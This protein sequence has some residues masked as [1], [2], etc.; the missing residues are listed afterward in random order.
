MKSNLT[1]S[2]S[3]LLFA[4]FWCSPI[5]LWAQPMEVANGGPFTPENLITNIF[6]G[7]GVE[8]LDVTFEGNAQS[9]GFFSN[10][11]D[12]IGI[13]RGLVMTTGRATSQ[14]GVGVDQN[15]NVQ[16]SSAMGTTFTDPDL[17]DITGGV[18]INDA[19][20]YTI[21]FVPIADTLRFNY[22]FGSEEYPEYA[23]SDF[24]DV[25]GF[26]ISGPGINGPYSNNAE[27][28]AL[29]P[30]SNLPVTINNVNPG[31]VGANGT[32][33]NCQPPSGSLDFS[34]FYVP[35]TGTANQPVFDG[36]TT[37][38]EAQAVVQPCSTYTIKLIV[39]D[40]SDSGWDSGVFLQAKSFG[41]GSLDVEAAT[42]SLDGSVAEGCAE[43]MLT[44]KLPNPPEADY[45]IDYQVLGTAENGVDYAFIP[46]DLFIPAGDTMVSVPIIAF[47]D[48]IEEG[49]ETILIDI[50]RDPCN[51]DTITIL[52]RENP[53]VPADLGPDTTICQGQSVLLDATLPVPLPDPPSFT[54]D[55]PVGI[56]ANPGN[57][58]ITS[59]VDV[60]GVIPP[61]LG[62]G[63]I[64]SVC[65]DSLDHRWIDDLDVFLIAPDGQFLE[66]TTDNGG[67][68]GN[69]LGID[70]F[71]N[72]CFTPEATVNINTVQPTDN[73]FTGNWQ[74]EGPW[75]DL[76]G[77]DKNTNGT[78][79]LQITDDTNSAGGT[80]YSW[81][82]TFNPVYEI[83]YSWA[84]AAGLSC[85]DCPNPVATPDTTTTYIMTAT[86]SYGCTTSDTVVI[87]VLPAL[88]AP[89]VDC[90][91][92]TGSSITFTW[93]DVAGAS[94]YEVNIDST[95]WVPA[96]GVNEH[97]ITGLPFLTEVHIQV[98]GL[99][100]CPGFIGTAIC[101]TLDCTPP[102]VALLSQQDVTCFGGADGSLTVEGSGTLP[103]YA[104]AIGSEQNTTGQFTGLAAGT[105]Q[106]AVI[107][108]TGCGGVLPV[109]IVQPDSLVTEELV[110]PVS[111][112]GLSDGEAGLNILNGTAPYSYDWGGGITA[113]VRTGLPAADYPLAITDG[114]GCTY[115]FTVTVT[116][117][118]SL[119]G[120]VL[121]GDV[122]CAGD[123]TGTIALSFSGG[124]AP[125]AISYSGGLLAEPGDSTAVANV[126][127]GSYSIIVSD[128]NNCELT[129]P[130]E[131]AE[132]APITLQLSGQDAL[133]ADSLS[134]SLSV[135]A[136]GGTGGLSYIWEDSTGAVVSGDS[137]ASGVGAGQY[138]LAVSDENGCVATDSL[139]IAEPAALTATVDTLPASCNGLSDGSVNVQASGGI[140]PYIYSW[141]D[142]TNTASGLRND[143]SSGTYEVSIT[144][145][146][147]CSLVE[148]FAITAPA[149]VSVSLTAGAVSCVGSTDGVAEVMA[150]GGTA[151]YAYLWSGGQ[152]DSLALGFAAGQAAVT[153][154]DA[155]GC[156]AIDSVLVPDA[157]PLQAALAG[158]GPSCAGATDG[159]AEITAAGGAG[160]FAYNWSDGQTGPA[161]GNLP[162]G[163]IGVTLTDA[164]GCTLIDSLEL[165]EPDPL[166]SM[167]ISETASCLP[168]P[169]GSAQVTVSG[170]TPG[171]EYEWSDG[172]TVPGPQGLEA[173]VYIVTVTDA[174]GCTL[175]DTVEVAG[176][177]EIELEAV[178]T[179]A[180]CFEGADGAASVSAAGGDGNYTYNWSNGVGQPSLSNL[181]AGGYTV[182]V[183]DG[184][185]CTSVAAVTVQQPGAILIVPEVDMITCS[186]GADGRA[187]IQVSGGT[188]PY[189]ASWS[190]GITGLENTN[191]SLGTYTVQVTDANGCQEMAAVE[192]TE[193]SPIIVSSDTEDV[194]CFGERTGSASVI[195]TGG[196]PPYQYEWSNGA[197]APQLA[198][199]EA[200]V[201]GLTITDAANCEVA[202]NLTVVQP[203][204]PLRAEVAPLDVSC[205]GEE[206]GRL[207]ISASGGTPAYRYS[208]D[209][210][211][212]SGSSTFIALA[213]GSYRV[214]VTDA[215]GCAFFSD[216]VT[217]GEPEE[218]V[219]DLG[220]T[221]AIPYGDT[222][223]LVPA[224]TGGIAPFG[225]DWFPLDS[226][227]LSCFGC[228]DPLAT[229]EF[230][231]NIRVVVTDIAGCTG[232]DDFNLYA[233]KI[234]PVEVPTGFTPNGDGNNDVLYVLGREGQNIAIGVFRV[235][236]RWGELVFEQRDIAP[237]MPSAGWDG[238][239]RS[240]PLQPGVYLWYIELEYPDGLIEA[241]SGQTTLIR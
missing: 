127:A 67:N 3:N 114:S 94:S 18:G 190:N 89:M 112:A 229:V 98:R 4:L 157:S 207:D 86:D 158:E 102:D 97:T 12:E 54:N 88:D 201:Y 136:A 205:F 146:N 13:G 30:G 77:S 223:R 194:D 96:N 120:D 227:I 125:Y 66:L 196:L 95:G 236:D 178:A 221:R 192:I 184:L 108:G 210:D 50:Q 147:G 11:D 107:D 166:S 41:T 160:G 74:P 186:G 142:G 55:T 49:E 218:I 90:G 133:C 8:V 170:G 43:G 9:V 230:Q 208:I 155:N 200:G 132:P 118:D 209:G 40:V 167:I 238:N 60:I 128:Q 78:W 225:Y 16:S 241:F 70:Y 62:P 206:D 131:V 103:P 154:T 37:V 26:F 134:G 31:Q 164:N 10:A 181:T 87:E 91:T 117:P 235:F 237:N 121:I 165:T 176:I 231:Q 159:M 193:A 32:L 195:I 116:E 175:T 234:R 240:E 63:V 219:V 14:G 52:V 188:G 82:I 46:P 51:R 29:I 99:G 213:P 189:T 199:L 185:G 64:R 59:E 212:F 76:Y 177:P 15:G 111:C 36:F 5:L 143:L 187:A 135:I 179:P 53:L 215:K 161:A 1:L 191:L 68:G 216:P 113:P 233:E 197:T 232:E 222:I 71:I 38:L 239:Y 75:S 101:T 145:G 39:A 73:P 115:N 84:P 45:P 81:T 183:S 140:G 149:S 139:L 220:G 180:S 105:Y 144:D 44:F 34:D 24:N 168:Q 141:P 19:V 93:P 35:N 85:A 204:A 83:S 169:D 151:P 150:T 27:N 214:T 48:G 174:N 202:E 56:P 152:A 137:L 173:G 42:V 23:C 171:Y 47:E 162:A 25:F 138:Y 92:V 61:T 211:F 163:V 129:L 217:V 6:L 22:V 100:E 80:L 106:V 148:G 182:T 224:I 226:S 203:D 17:L 65:I 172:Q 124:T 119:L 79:Q 21:T 104:Y 122:A 7:D 33:A 126:P 69:S 156:Q 57:I 72:T 2:F 130:A 153:V 20:R 109:T 198:N 228:S 28:I 58:S 123:S 110:Q